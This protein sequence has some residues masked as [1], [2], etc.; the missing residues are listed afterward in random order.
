MAPVM[1]KNPY[2][3]A[4]P[5]IPLAAKKGYKG[6]SQGRLEW[7]VESAWVLPVEGREGVKWLPAPEGPD[8]DL[9]DWVS[10]GSVSCLST[11]GTSKNNGRQVPRKELK[12]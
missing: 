1:V 2:L 6:F 4:P 12:T 10:H 3:L 7:Q 11:L 8:R 9:M 5:S